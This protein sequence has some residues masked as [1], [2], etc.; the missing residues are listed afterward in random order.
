MP[1]IKRQIIKYDTKEIYFRKLFEE[2][3]KNNTLESYLN[4][5]KKTKLIEEGY[6][7]VKSKEFEELYLKLIKYIKKKF[8]LDFYYQFLPSLRFQ[9]PGD[10]ENP[11]HI[12]TWVGHGKDIVNFWLPLVELNSQN[13]LH[14]VNEKNSSFLISKFKKGQLSLSDFN[15]ICNEYSEPIKASY[16]DLALFSNETLHGQKKNSSD[17]T[18]LSLDFR[19]IPKGSSPGNR[20]IGSFYKSFDKEKN[21]NKKKKPAISIVYNLN[22]VEHISNKAQREIIDN[23]CERNDLEIIRENGEWFGFE[24]YPQLSDHLERQEYPIVIFSLHCLPKNSIKRKKILT[25]L[26]KYSKGVHFALENI[27]IG[28][29]SDSAVSKYF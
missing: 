9:Q 2:L 20:K 14:I 21:K 1:A 12:D 27:K 15:K 6:K 17:K 25:K 5:S 4:K 8:G 22:K 7:I 29:L 24:H 18:R 28:K 13:T 26:R 23:Y 16:G 19:I 11:F 3:A 10:N